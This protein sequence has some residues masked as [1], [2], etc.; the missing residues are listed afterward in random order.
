MGVDYTDPQEK[1]MTEVKQDKVQAELIR[2]I[3]KE[4]PC[5]LDEPM[6]VTVTLDNG[7]IY[8]GVVFEVKSKSDD[9]PEGLVMV[10][11]ANADLGV[12]V[13]YVSGRD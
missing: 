2:V 9:Y 6:P 3:Q 7:V 1:L 11:T 12:P 4:A 5:T 8:K 13:T 10:R